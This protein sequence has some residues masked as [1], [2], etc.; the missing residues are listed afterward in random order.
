MSKFLQGVPKEPVIDFRVRVPIGACP[1]Q[2]SPAENTERY[3]AVLGT[4]TKIAAASSLDDLIGQLD[5]SGVDLAVLH[6]E[7]EAGDPADDLN[8]VVADIVKQHPTRFVG[9]GTVSLANFRISRALR[10]VEACAEK[11]MIGLSLQPAF[12]DMEIG[13]KRLYPVYAKAIE[14]NL[15]VALHTGI[16]YSTNRPMAGEHPMQIDQLSCHFPELVVVASHSGWPWATEMVAVARRHPNVFLEFGGLSPKYVGAPG[17]G[18]DVAYRYINSL[19][20]GQALFATDWP[21]MDHARVIR[22]WRELGLKPAVER[23]LLG[24][25]AR[26][27]IKTM[28]QPVRNSHSMLPSTANS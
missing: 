8:R 17:T 4:K 24:G 27:L 22:E 10:Q 7:Y 15:L 5:A 14:N 26:Q 11:G 28:G 21:V 16:N 12:F 23:A 2:E 3:E 1:A 19:L 13:D 18:W 6:A 25:N 20:S 9:I